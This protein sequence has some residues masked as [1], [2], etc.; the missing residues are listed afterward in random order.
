MIIQ[1]H[2]IPYSDGNFWYERFLYP[3]LTIKI[4]FF[5]VKLFSLSMLMGCICKTNEL[6]TPGCAV[7]QSWISISHQPCFS[8]LGLLTVSHTRD[9][10]LANVSF[11][12]E[13]I[14]FSVNGIKILATVCASV[15][16]Y[17]KLNQ[18]SYTNTQTRWYVYEK[19][20][21]WEHHEKRYTLRERDTKWLNVRISNQDKNKTGFIQSLMFKMGQKKIIMPDELRR[22]QWK[23]W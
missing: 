16:F 2:F 13:D 1:I 6:I 22:F 14:Y 8:W 10:S 11:N 21:K 3:S 9:R 20:I 19:G 17:L 18:T 7:I 23:S 4:V 5:P 12:H 15:D